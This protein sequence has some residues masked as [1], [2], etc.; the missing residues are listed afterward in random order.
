M[1]K[2]FFN[3]PGGVSFWVVQ[4]CFEKGAAEGQSFETTDLWQVAPGGNPK[5]ILQAP[6]Q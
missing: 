2:T 5:L 3:I 1:I 4:A 6:W